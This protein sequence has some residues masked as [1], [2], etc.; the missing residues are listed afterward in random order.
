MSELG[1]DR[2]V[3]FQN[4]SLLPWLSVYENV[5]LAVDQVLAKTRTRRERRG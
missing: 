1:P 4:P 3:V 5:R 2:A